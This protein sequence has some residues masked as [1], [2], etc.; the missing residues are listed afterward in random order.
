MGRA[1]GVREPPVFSV[2]VIVRNEARS[3]PRLVA[4]LAPFQARGGDVLVVDT[5]STDGTVATARAHGCRVEEVGARFTAVL[6]ADEI[7]AINAQFV[8]EGEGPLVSSRTGPW[9]HFAA[10]R[11]HAAAL[12]H[13]DPVLQLDAS[14][15]LLSFD[16]DA[17]DAQLREGVASAFEY[18]LHLGTTT[19]RVCRFYDRRL[20][21]WR[22]RAHE[23]L[24]P[25]P[26]APGH[27]GPTVR[28]P[29]SQLSVRHHKDHAKVRNYV[30]GLALDVI[31]RPDMPRWKHYLGRE[32]WYQHRYRSAIRVLLEHADDERAPR[33]ER[34]ESLCLAGQCFEAVG[35]PAPAER[36]YRRAVAVDPARREPLLRLAALATRGP[37]F[38]ATVAHAAAALTLP[39][40]SAFAE[41]DLNYAS[42][43]HVFL[44]W[45][46]FWL[47]RQDEARWHW[48]ESRRLAPDD[49]TVRDHARLFRAS[50]EDE[51][52]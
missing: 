11:Q 35:E 45:G 50:V 10:A 24:Y 4:G 21:H 38:E 25:I 9:F 44:Y 1:A 16:L 39:R 30:A 40:T 18:T 2:A 23:G 46:L 6:T 15:E 12:A 29:E 28:C 49:P 37:D 36:S 17:I 22:G 8:S 19:L 47:G 32:L 42:L 27:R 41:S 20:D 48:E 51:R 14:D 33:A 31:E 34:S 52:R 5:A 26:G 7:D 13:R 43:P 3:L